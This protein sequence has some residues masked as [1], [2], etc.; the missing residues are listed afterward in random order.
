[1][2]VYIHKFNNTRYIVQ[3]NLQKVISWNQ[4]T[5]NS[6]L[7]GD[8]RWILFIPH[9]SLQTTNPYVEQ[10][11]RMLD[12]VDIQNDGTKLLP[13]R[14][15]ADGLQN[16]RLFETNL[17]MLCSRRGHKKVDL[18]FLEQGGLLKDLQ[19][20][21]PH[22]ELPP[23]IPCSIGLCHLNAAHE[24]E[25]IKCAPHTQAPKHPSTLAYLKYICGLK[26]RIFVPSGWF[27]TKSKLPDPQI[28]TL[29]IQ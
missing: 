18:K 1:M 19:W 16:Q 21:S 22:M 2:K 26:S 5:V 23:K 13:H 20:S 12:F 17:Q 3:W 25:Y 8:V 29:S 14:L 27:L 24:N 15:G 4:L 10:Y 6:G 7:I 28:Q 9:H 11:P